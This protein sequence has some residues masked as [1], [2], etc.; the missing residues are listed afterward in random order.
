MNEE[1]ENL[2]GYKG[3]DRRPGVPESIQV[4]IPE[5]LE[6][7]VPAY[8][9][10]RR[11]ELQEIAALVAASDFEGML[12]LAHNIKGSG[13]SYGFAELT[14]LGRALE[15]SAHDSDLYAVQGCLAQ[16]ADYLGRVQPIS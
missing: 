10:A 6:A 5:G 9:S 4:K 15:S 8:L 3:C 16:L 2:F 1:T 11:E 7:L 13:T 14:R 12:P